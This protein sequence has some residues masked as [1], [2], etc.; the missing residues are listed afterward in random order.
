MIPFGSIFFSYGKLFVSKIIY[1]TFFF[2]QLWVFIYEI[3]LLKLPTK[4][5]II[6]TYYSGWRWDKILILIWCLFGT[7]IKK[8]NNFDSQTINH[9][10]L[11]STFLLFLYFLLYSHIE[12]PTT[13]QKKK[14]KKNCTHPLSNKVLNSYVCSAIRLCR[15][16]SC[17]VVYRGPLVLWEKIW[18]TEEKKT[19]DARAQKYTI[20]T[21]VASHG[22]TS[23]PL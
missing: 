7:F 12:I 22:K 9:T 17:P 1:H 3:K 11:L 23:A 2:F 8:K 13:F 16:C 4:I 18:K 20:Y 21:L 5:T 6:V 14:R 10:I 15:L 19:S